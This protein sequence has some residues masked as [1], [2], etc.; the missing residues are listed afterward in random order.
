MRESSVAT[1]RRPY[2]L[3]LSVPGARG[4]VAAGTVGRSAHLMTVLSVVFYLS[5]TRSYALAG[6]VAAGYQVGYSAVGPFSARLYD[7]Y[8]QGRVLPW[9]AVGTALSRAVLLLACWRGAAGWALVGLA[10]AA[11]AAMPSVG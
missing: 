7:R 9:A 6:S 1:R 3:V 8:G 4:F 11:G 2:A 10:A 5:A